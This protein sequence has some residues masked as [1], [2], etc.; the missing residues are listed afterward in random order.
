MAVPADD[1]P[2]RNLIGRASES[3]RFDAAM[4]QAL[5]G[6]RAVV[7]LE[8]E[9]GIGKTTFLHEIVTSAEHAGCTAFVGRCEDL[10]RHRPFAALADAV[11][12]TLNSSDSRRASLAEAIEGVH[13]TLDEGA[14]HIRL[15]PF[16]ENGI[17]TLATEVLGRP[18]EAGCTLY[19]RVH[20][21][22]SSTGL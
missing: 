8:G 15:S 20:G 7:L 4:A 19:I 12:C 10:D 6:R 21:S 3:A 5:T 14:A 11:G 2:P 9:A 16:D 13:R 18:E 1:R 22:A 17:V